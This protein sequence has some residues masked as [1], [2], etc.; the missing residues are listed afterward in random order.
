MWNIHWNPEID[1]K[2]WRLSWYRYETFIT[3]LKFRFSTR[4]ERDTIFL[5][6]LFVHRQLST[7]WL[8]QRDARVPQSTNSLVSPRSEKINSL[9]LSPNLNSL[10]LFK[11]TKNPNSSL[12]GVT[13][14]TS[15][16]LYPIWSFYCV[17]SVV[18]TLL[19]ARS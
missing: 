12:P 6:W 4:E 10:L 13:S 9:C 18:I 17:R 5:Y 7:H 2:H 19:L 3:F 11:I 16:V 15:P 14:F 8:N 1:A